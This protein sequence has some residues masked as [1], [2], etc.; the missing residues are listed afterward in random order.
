MLRKTTLAVVFVIA[1][2]AALYQAGL[3]VSVD[4]SG[5]MPRFVTNSPDYDALEEDRARQR[6]LAPPPPVAAA[7]QPAAALAALPSPAASQAGTPPAV[8]DT[9]ARAATSSPPSAPDRDAWPGFRGDLRDGR[10]AAA[11]V[12]AAWPPEGLPELWRHPI[13]VGYASFVIAN[14]R[15]FT[16]E[17]RRSQEVVAAYDLDTGREVWTVGWDG[18]FLE[19]MGGDGPRATPTYHDGRVYALGALGELRCLDARTGAV[20]WRKNILEENEVRNLTWGMA[21]AP[22][23]V[24]DVVVVM[25]GGSRDRSIVAYDLQTGERRW[26]ALGDQAAYTS[27]MLVTLGGLRQILAVTARRAVGLTVDGRLLWEFPWANNQGINAAQPLLIGGDR[28][29]LSA[30]YGSGATVVQI[31]RNGDQFTAQAVWENQRLKNRFSS[32][33]LHEGHIYGLDE[34]ILTCIDAATGEARWKAGRY[35]YGQLMIAGD[36]LIVLT[37]DGRVAL[38]R[39][40]PEG[41]EEL[42]SF[43]AIEGKTWNHPV[44]ADG[45]LIVRN[46]REM[47]AFDIRPVGD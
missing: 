11:P 44:I 26:S 13:G 14:G 9:A 15:A 28:V 21:A 5:F 7:A 42:A 19:S 32:S 4:G 35:G 40:T 33:V 23:I 43:D 47:A 17:Q 39:A 20:I 2:A 12:R 16:I 24:D 22:L 27:P 30:S 34:S 46:G 3:R 37:E 8:P 36:R 6:A 45:R 31:A 10:Y 38:V 41:H 18:E 29:F 25:P 1:C